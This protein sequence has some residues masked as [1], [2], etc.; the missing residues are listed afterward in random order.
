[1]LPVPPHE[2]RDDQ[3]M[4]PL[5][6]SPELVPRW[7]WADLCYRDDLSVHVSAK[8]CVE[9]IYIIC[10]SFCWL[11]YIPPLSDKVVSGLRLLCLLKTES[12]LENAME[13]F[14]DFSPND[15]QEVGLFSK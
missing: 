9:T 8:L 14:S 6:C 7:L 2:I 4:P 1:M 10:F 3:S 13:F 5:L 15:K 12:L 11:S